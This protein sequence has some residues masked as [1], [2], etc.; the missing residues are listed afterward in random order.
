MISPRHSKAAVLTGRRD[1]RIESRVLSAI[2]PA[3]I[4]VR[5]HGCGICGSNLPAWEGRPWFQYPFEPGAPGHEGWGVVEEIGERVTDLGP[6]DPVAILSYH[7]FAE[8][9]VADA[10]SAVRL[11]EALCDEPFPGEAIACAVNVFRRARVQ[12]GQTVAVVGIGFLGALLV[13]LASRAGAYVIAISRRPFSL[14]IGAKMGANETVPMEPVNDAI[15]RVRALTGGRGCDVVIEAAGVQSTLD[16]ASELCAERGHL[17]IAG[18]HQDGPRQVNMQS[19]NWRGLDVTNAHERDPKVYIQGM[20]DAVALVEAGKLDPT[21]L[22]SRR[23]ELS[24]IGRAFAETSQ[25]EKSFLKAW[26]SYV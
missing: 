4:R 7:A 15:A 6:G 25:A 19:W 13:Q 16:L 18:Y 14:S 23:Y 9:D 5:L 8:H 12:P 3:E 11:S 22:Y 17:V 2:G 26:V 21:P 1:L 10:A 24:E 20:R